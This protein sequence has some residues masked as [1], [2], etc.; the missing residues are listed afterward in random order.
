[1]VG[2]EAPAIV[3]GL[4]KDMVKVSSGE[5]K[6][7]NQPNLLSF[8]K[9]SSSASSRGGQKKRTGSAH[10]PFKKSQVEQ[11][12]GSVYVGGQLTKQNLL[13]L[14]ALQKKTDK[15]KKQEIM[16]TLETSIDP[17]NDRI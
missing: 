12:G 4:A 8:G 6:A 10:N 7:R 5:F 1:M 11:K 15:Q 16:G 3:S 13:R 2:V 9:I 17:C 14:Q